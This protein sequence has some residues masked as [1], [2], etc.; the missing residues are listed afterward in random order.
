MMVFFGTPQGW[1]IFV[2]RWLLQLCTPPPP[3]APVTKP[4]GLGICQ[5]SRGVT[6][7][8][9]HLSKVVDRPG[10]SFCLSHAAFWS[11]GKTVFFCYQWSALKCAKSEFFSSML[12]NFVK[13]PMYGIR[14]SPHLRFIA[15][16]WRQHMALKKVQ[17]SQIMKTCAP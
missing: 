12:K 13:T 10:P 5:N 16:S 6:S 14:T 7:S 11:L 9:I 1:G 3:Q 4:G 2:E 17:S 15:R 8:G